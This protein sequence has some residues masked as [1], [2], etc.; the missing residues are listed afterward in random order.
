[1]RV[2]T[3]ND[4]NFGT[5]AGSIYMAYFQLKEQLATRSAGRDAQRPRRH[6]HPVR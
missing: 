3:I 6:T 2:L 5:K 4:V 1:M